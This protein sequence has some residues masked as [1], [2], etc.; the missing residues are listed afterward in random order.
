L[1]N[2]ILR[3]GWAGLKEY[4]KTTCIENTVKDRYNYSIKYQRYLLNPNTV[5]DLLSFSPNKRL[6]IMKA[7]SSLS[8]FLGYSDVWQQAIKRNNIKWSTGNSSFVVFDKIV[9]HTN[10]SVMM[11][12]IRQVIK[13]LSQSHSNV[14][15]F[16]ILIGLRPSESI[17]SVHLLQQDLDSYWNK[18]KR[19]IGTL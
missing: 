17:K 8:K 18:D 9:N 4:L 11:D 14:I 15:I 7:L 6:H 12:W 16:N 3:I 10:Y 2:D 1:S 19:N 13:I 5:S